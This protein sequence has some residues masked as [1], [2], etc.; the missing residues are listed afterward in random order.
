MLKKKER[1]SGLCNYLFISGSMFSV[2][3]GLLWLLC[4]LGKAQFIIFSVMLNKL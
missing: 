3:K 2:L 4:T 1:F